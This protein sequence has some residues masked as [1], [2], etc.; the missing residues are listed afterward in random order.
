MLEFWLPDIFINPSNTFQLEKAEAV[1]VQFLDIVFLLDFCN[2]A[3]VTV[4][5]A[6]EGVSYTISTAS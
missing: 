5:F 2:S 1:N 6:S 3:S 4:S